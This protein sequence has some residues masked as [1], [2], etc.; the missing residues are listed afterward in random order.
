MRWGTLQR[1]EKLGLAPK[2]SHE[3]NG[4]FC[5]RVLQQVFHYAKASQNPL[6]RTSKVP[7][8]FLERMVEPRL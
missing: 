6:G 1:S 5:V 4:A 3:P 2:V 8:K 7:Q